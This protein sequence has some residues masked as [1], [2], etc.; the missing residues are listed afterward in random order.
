[1][2]HRRARHFARI[3]G[4]LVPDIARLRLAARAA[5]LG[6]AALAAL[7]LSFGCAPLRETPAWE[8]PPPPATDA[9]VVDASRLHR[10]ELSNGLRVIVLEDARLPRIEIGVVARRGAGIVAPA[11]AGLAEFTAELM[12]R[13]AGDRDALELAAVVDN[14]GATLSAGADWDSSSASVWGLSRDL[15]TLFAVLTDVVR[16]PRF[17]ADEAERVRAE[18]LA[19]IEKAKDSPHVLAS[20]AFQE[21]LYAGHR[22]G[23]PSEGAADAVAKLGAEDAR[24]FHEL[25]FSPGNCIFF[26]TGDLKVDDILARVESGFGD[27]SPRMVPDPGP[28][29]PG[30]TPAA[31]RIVIVDRPD[32]DQAQIVIGHEGIARNDPERLSASLMNTILGG[33][34]FSSRLTQSLRNEAGLT[35]SVFSF[36]ALRRHPGPFGVSTFTRV[37]EVRRVVDLVL[38]ELSRIRSDPPSDEEVANAQS[39]TVGQFAL[40]LETSS[41]VLGSLVNLDVY[42]LPEDSLDTFRPRIRALT[43]EDTAATAR[44]LVHPERAAIL[45]V[46]P[47]EAIAPQLEDLG[48]IEVVEP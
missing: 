41:A 46:G 1:M 5:W 24:R 19:G 39:Q 2:K 18:Q 22:Y 20:R 17:D 35:Y 32:L 21:A 34:A 14:L 8:L 48:D 47:A 13:G 42:G 23:L 4:V 43:P 36:F 25:V 45:V 9:A 31:R 27:W 11:Q 26:A 7:F 6:G 28:P 30:P 3:R 15:D 33:S 40:G 16:R 44:K 10:A 29:P 38:G 12:E 37:P